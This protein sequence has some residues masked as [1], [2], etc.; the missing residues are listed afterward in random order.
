MTTIDKPRRS[1]AEGESQFQKLQAEVER[2]D[3]LAI[4]YIGYLPLFNVMLLVSN[5]FAVVIGN[6]YSLLRIV[7]VG[8]A[9]IYALTSDLNGKL[10]FIE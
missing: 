3:K 7:C 10:I 2:Q 9:E 1:A 5:I 6:Y 4:V 8:S